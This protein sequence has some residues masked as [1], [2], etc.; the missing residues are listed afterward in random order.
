[1][2]PLCRRPKC[3]ALA[4]ATEKGIRPVPCFHGSCVQDRRCERVKLLLAGNRND[5]GFP[6]RFSAMDQPMCSKGYSPFRMFSQ[7]RVR[8]AAVC[9]RVAEALGAKRPSIPCRRPVCTA[10]SMGCWAYSL[11]LEASGK[12]LRDPPAAVSTPCMAA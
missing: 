8:N 2:P 5:S 9:A 6:A 10:H 1:M 7:K 4:S 11:T 12:L 3:W